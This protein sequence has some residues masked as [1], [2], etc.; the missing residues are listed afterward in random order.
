M[1]DK[2][3]KAKAIDR[4]EIDIRYNNSDTLADRYSNRA[5]ERIK[6][7]ES[8]FYAGID[9]RRR[10][11]MADGGM[12]RESKTEMANLP[13]QAIHTEYPPV[14]YYANPFIDDSTD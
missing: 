2:A 9:P 10:Q 5:Y 14:G 8:N 1:S 7:M 6:A 4:N 12:V 11:E 3:R 13:R